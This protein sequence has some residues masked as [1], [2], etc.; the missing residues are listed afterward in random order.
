MNWV[1]QGS[2]TEY[3]VARCA[4]VAREGLTDD[5][6]GIIQELQ[7]ISVVVYN[8]Q[9]AY[10]TTL[11]AELAEREKENRF[12]ITLLRDEVEPI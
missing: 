5:M 8:I 2:E 11:K 4:R 10:T 9:I 3:D 12:L 7:R 6:H 1:R